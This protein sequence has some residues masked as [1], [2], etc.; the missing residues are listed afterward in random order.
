[1]I[2]CADSCACALACRFG[3]ESQQRMVPQVMH[4]RR[5]SQPSPVFKHSSQPSIDAG[6]FVTAT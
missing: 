6:S 1:M 4:M 5:C 3:D 2:G